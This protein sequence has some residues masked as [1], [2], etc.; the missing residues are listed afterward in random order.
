[1]TIKSLRIQTKHKQ[2]VNRAE[3]LRT[4]IIVGTAKLHIGVYGSSSVLSVSHMESM[5]EHWRSV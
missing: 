2:Y 4:V 1:M 5:S 3:Q